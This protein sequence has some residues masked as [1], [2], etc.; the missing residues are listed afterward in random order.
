[1]GEPIAAEI[2]QTNNIVKHTRRLFLCFA[3]FIGCVT[4]IYLQ[5]KK[6][7]IERINKYIF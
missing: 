4:A 7:N 1:M 2:A 3:Y 6:E 5:K